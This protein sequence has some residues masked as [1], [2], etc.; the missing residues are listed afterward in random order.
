MCK[1]ASATR[2]WTDSV[3]QTAAFHSVYKSF[4]YEA[5][6]IFFKS[7]NCKECDVDLQTTFIGFRAEQCAP[8]WPLFTLTAASGARQRVSRRRSMSSESGSGFKATV[9]Q[10][11]VYVGKSGSILYIFGIL[12]I[13]RLFAVP[14]GTIFVNLNFVDFSPKSFQSYPFKGPYF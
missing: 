1:I 7:T 5:E 13:Y 2:N 14:L 11:K 12:C 4:F 10:D 9:V 3:P 6:V 8:C